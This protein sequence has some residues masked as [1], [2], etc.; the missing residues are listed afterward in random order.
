MTYIESSRSAERLLHLGV[1]LNLFTFAIHP[2]PQRSGP[3]GP[4]LNLSTVR[5]DRGR[6][7]TFDI[8]HHVLELRQLV[9]TLLDKTFKGLYFLHAYRSKHILRAH[10]GMQIA[11]DINSIVFL[12][13]YAR[14]KY[15]N[16]QEADQTSNTLIIPKSQWSSVLAQNFREKL[17]LDVIVEK[18]QNHRFS[19]VYLLFKHLLRSL[20]GVINGG[21]PEPEPPDSG[22]SRIMVSY[23]MGVDAQRR[24]DISF[25]HA[26]DGKMDPSRLLFY[27]RFK[28]LY[29]SEDELKWFKAN[30]IP[31]Y[32]SELVKE[33]I[34]SL[35]LWQPSPGFR[36][37]LYRFYHLFL[38]TA[39]QSMWRRKHWLWLLDTLWD[40][41]WNTAWWQDF[42]V[43]NNV[44]VIVHS[45]PGTWNFT[46]NLAIGE[47]GGIAVNLERSILFD[48]CTFFHNA[49]NHVNFVTGSYSLTQIPE[50]SFSTYTL[51]VGGINLGNHPPIPWVQEKQAQGKTVIA[52]FDELP[53]DWYF[54][55]AVR[56]F[57]EALLELVEGNED[58]SESSSFSPFALI[59]K[60]KKPEVLER[61]ESLN[62]RIIRLTQAGVCLFPD[63][64]VTPA[65]AA[66]LSDLVVCV[67]STAAFES[68]LT[69]TPTVVFSPMKSGSSL[70]YTNNG[71]NRRIFEDPAAMVEAIRAF[72][73]GSRKE[74]GDCTDLAIQIDPYGD[75]KGAER[76]GHYLLQSLEAF[77]RSQSRDEILEQANHDFVRQYGED[78]LTVSNIP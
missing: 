18:R 1:K 3:A 44:R 14:W 76:L 43:A 42:F 33:D 13:N 37:Y 54:G 7:I 9:L 62:E 6:V 15:Y 61:L 46:P 49:P 75:G 63:W 57:Y 29:P 52:V 70:F 69:G 23:A 38:R 8:N 47:S 40:M 30:N 50:P 24:N 71:L 45:V 35:P 39:V 53:N 5:D 51:Q 25:L 34:P 26:L 21:G 77:D 16:P 36:F 27:F 41:G 11:R 64:K 55:D 31:C 12:A 19:T 78:K 65:N 72:G 60:T 66:A 10:L 59:I 32:T 67:P 22:F 56:Q 20:T 4:V 73:D 48:Y 28:N 17:G 74:V 58:L 2:V 68:V